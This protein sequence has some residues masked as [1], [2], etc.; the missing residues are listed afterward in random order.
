[1]NGRKAAKI[2]VDA[3]LALSLVVT[4]A[5]ALVQEVPHEWVGIVTFAFLVAH[6]VLNRRWIA[7]IPKGRYH[8]LRAV[9]VATMVALVACFVGQMVSSLVLSKHA[10]GF[11]PAIP[12]ASWARRVHMACAYWL[13]VLAFVHAGFHIRM[14]RNLGGWQRWALRVGLV[15]AAGY[16]VWAF[17]QLNLAPYL[18]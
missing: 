8:A 18:L 10:L 12:G 17:V 9:Q 2:A 13:F 6:L 5:T 1:M 7:A 3:G 14:P 4:M 11:L 16:G 15:L